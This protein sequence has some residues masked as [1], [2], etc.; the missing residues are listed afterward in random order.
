M[1]RWL[2]Q[3]LYGSTPAEF[4]SAYGLVESVE[5]LRAATKRSVFSALGETTAVGRVT[6]ERVRLQRVIPMVGNSFK[7]FFIGRFEERGGAV[8]LTGKF[9]MLGF[10]KVFMTFWLGMTALVAVAVLL[11]SL[12]PLG[13]HAGF[14][15]LQPLLMM[16]AGIGVVAAGQWFAR[17]DVAWLSGVIERALAASRADASVTRGALGEVDSGALPGTLKGVAAFLAV[18][19]AMAVF[20]G[21]AGPG[22][23]SAGPGARALALPPWGPWMFVYAGFLVVLSIGVWRRQPWAWR[24]FFGLLGLSAVWPLYALYGLQTPLFVGPPVWM[25]GVFAILSCAVVAIW[26]R[27]WYAQRRHFL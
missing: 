18:M 13:P 8:V 1:I 14:F 17:N 9:T 2:W 19:G 11:G 12:G 4:R 25:G 5:R 26:G 24:A 3:L 6:V 10:V 16:A 27:W 7:P 21:F 20:S 23:P 22:V 15:R